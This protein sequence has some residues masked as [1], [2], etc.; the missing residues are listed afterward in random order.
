MSG[1]LAL[2]SALAVLPLAYAGF[3]LAVR[4]GLAPERVPRPEA[5]P[6]RSGRAVAFAGANGKTLRGWLLPAEN[7][8][9][10]ALVSCTAGAA[11]PN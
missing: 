11:M 1:L 4:R 2:A 9:A 5:P 8:G 6:G 3:A 10:P 7:A